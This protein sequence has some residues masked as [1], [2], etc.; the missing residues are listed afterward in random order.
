MVSA[1]T[2]SLISHLLEYTCGLLSG[3]LVFQFL[4][5]KNTA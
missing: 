2:S 3:L 5:W 1:W 4:P